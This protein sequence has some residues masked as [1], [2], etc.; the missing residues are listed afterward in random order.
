MDKDVHLLGEFMSS[1]NPF[2]FRVV[3]VFRGSFCFF[4]VKP[5]RSSRERASRWSG[6]GARQTAPGAGALPFENRVLG[7]HM[8]R[9]GDTP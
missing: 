3:R 4:Q 1:S 7:Q 2:G 8:T 5:S 9:F 6:A